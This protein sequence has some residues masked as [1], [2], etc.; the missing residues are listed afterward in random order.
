M[1][2]E[3]KMDEMFKRKTANVLMIQGCEDY[4]VVVTEVNEIGGLVSIILLVIMLV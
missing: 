4:C 1:F 2:Y 3:T